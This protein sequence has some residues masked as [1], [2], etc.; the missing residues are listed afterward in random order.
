[1]FEFAYLYYGFKL[2]KLSESHLQI[3][4]LRTALLGIICDN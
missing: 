2:F 4:A 3:N 1:M